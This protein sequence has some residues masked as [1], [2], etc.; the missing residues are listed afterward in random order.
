M[1]PQDWP[2]QRKFIP[3]TAPSTAASKSASAKTISGFLPPKLEGDRLDE[4]AAALPDEPTDGLGTG[5]GDPGTS[6]C[7]DEALPDSGPGA[8][9]HVED[10]RRKE[11]GRAPRAAGPRARLLR[12]FEDDAVAREQRSGDP[13]RREHQRMVERD[14]APDDA[15]RITQREVEGVGRTGTVSPRT[16]S[17]RPAK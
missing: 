3:R 11:S 5:E 12:R 6:G 7:V 9:D 2:C 8:G 14:Q 15:E 13:R 10:A 17:A 1:D 4:V 16:C